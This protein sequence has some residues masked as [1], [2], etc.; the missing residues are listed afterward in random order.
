M[1]KR[2]FLAFAAGSLLA[3][4]AFADAVFML[5]FGSFES[6]AEAQSHLG[7]LKGKHAD[8][9]G[10][11]PTSI[12]TISLP[13]DN[14]T[15]YRTQAGP[16]ASRA[17]AQQVCSSFAASGDECYV[18][19]TAMV[20]QGE[21]TGTQQVNAPTAPA[22]QVAANA[23]PAPLTAQDMP[24]APPGAPTSLPPTASAQPMED[25]LSA[26]A[27]NQQ[28][29]QQAIA[30]AQPAQPSTR[31]SIWWHMNPFSEAPAAAPPAVAAAPASAP[32]E[33]VAT[34]TVTPPP[35]TPAALP[36]LSSLTDNAPPPSPAALPPTTPLVVNAA[37][38]ASP[39]PAPQEMAAA[40]VPPSMMHLPP[41][42]PP[43]RSESAPMAPAPAPQSVGTI[44]S[45]APVVLQP[46][47][48]NV[49]VGEAQR[50]P[51]SQQ[52][53]QPTVPTMVASVPAPTSLPTT[54]QAV[55]LYPS[56]TLGQKTLW[57]QVGM[58]PDAQSALAYWGK[59]P[60][61]APGFP[62][63]AR[64]RRRAVHG[65]AARQFA[66]GAARRS[67]RAAGVRA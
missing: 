2:L 3:S 42:P 14:L 47:P 35:P 53:P 32:V 50:V 43:L 66:G 20:A 60:P 9:I 45:P 15:V 39:P 51:L 16:V 38:V 7:E 28:A 59:L 57:A 6:Q 62:G 11:L 17:Q 67:L 63:R 25:E 31:K 55:S 40:D 23:Q 5:Q 37:P 30:S 65:A 36:P 24:P 26:A 4:N 1:K 18:V 34:A 27:A 48:G 44:P 19:E 8:L 33:E 10:G 21:P 46:A 41:P 56:S 61:G 58:F 22:P 12:R 49:R 52:N 54:Q 13:P 29:Q 64:A